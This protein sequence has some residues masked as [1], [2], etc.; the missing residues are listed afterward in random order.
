MFGLAQWGGVTV[1]WNPLMAWCLRAGTLPFVGVK[2][3]VGAGIAWFGWRKRSTVLVFGVVALA[4]VTAWNLGVLLF[5][6]LN[7]P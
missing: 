1:E 3:L 2:T 4:S 6:T 7:A 5:L